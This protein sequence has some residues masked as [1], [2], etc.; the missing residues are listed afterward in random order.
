MISTTND[1]F[2]KTLSDET[3]LLSICRSLWLEKQPYNI[4]E[5]IYYYHNFQHLDRDLP[6][7]HLLQPYLVHLL[8]LVR[9]YDW[10]NPFLLNQ[11]ALFALLSSV[12]LAF[13]RRYGVTI[14]ISAACLTASSP[15]LFLFANSAGFDFLSLCLLW[16]SV[17]C[18]ILGAQQR[19]AWIQ[20]GAWFAA[21][22]VQ[23]RY[24]NG[25]LVLGAFVFWLLLC[26][27]GRPTWQGWIAQWGQSSFASW[28]GIFNLMLVMANIQ[29]SLS[30]DKMENKDEALLSLGHLQNHLPELLRALFLFE[31]PGDHTVA[32]YRPLLWWTLLFLCLVWTYRW[33][34]KQNWEQLVARVRSPWKWQTGLF[35]A[36]LGLVF[37]QLCI[38]LS[39]YFGRPTHPTAVRYYL[40]LVCFASW[41]CCWLI[42]QLR[43]QH[44]VRAL[45]LTLVGLLLLL[46]WP[47]AQNQRFIN[48]LTLN[49]ET[50]HIY[51]VVLSEPRKDTLY[52]H[53]R[54]GQI[55][56]LE[57]G[58][59]SV[60]RANRELKK[61]QKN[62]RQGLIQELIYLRRTDTDSA[63]DQKL[64]RGD[65]HRRATLHGHH[66][67]RTRCP[68]APEEERAR[69]KLLG[70]GI[71]NQ[72]SDHSTL[73][74]IDLP[75]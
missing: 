69:L 30:L 66:Q 32:P 64:L 8:H 4:T 50:K 14:G 24:E 62:L 15:L 17:L 10:R 65:W 73:L 23:I 44:L 51:E 1:S 75:A 45:F 37:V 11:L 35:C 26:W 34:T 68:P 54:P 5:G 18:L 19:P 29:T 3:N 12:A 61:Y 21:G 40:P 52:I 71:P 6:K 39:H 58:A 56:V 7:R 9:G 47:I 49:R 22:F 46:Y 67:T 31:V 74:I 72:R 70:S 53:E 36:A 42:L 60:R 59:V 28:L 63:K 55:A 33:S 20:L 57:R 16:W 43:S 2:Y 27:P 48:Q 13:G 38:F 41:S 25:V